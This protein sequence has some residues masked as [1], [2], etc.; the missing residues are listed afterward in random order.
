M[1]SQLTLTEVQTIGAPYQPS[2]DTS[3][4]AAVAAGPKQGTLK[5]RIVRWLAFCEDGI[6]QDEMSQVLFKPRQSM[7]APFNALVREGRIRKLDGVTRTSQYG[8]ACSVY[9]LAPAGRIG[10]EAPDTA[11]RVAELS[12]RTS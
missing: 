3:I 10:E 12:D 1:T 7:C 5:D 2:S 4:A 9:V 11:L 6:T 8:S